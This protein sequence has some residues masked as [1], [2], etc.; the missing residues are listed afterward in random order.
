MRQIVFG[1]QLESIGIDFRNITDRGGMAA[2]YSPI[3]SGI[4]FPHDPDSRKFLLEL[5]RAKHMGLRR[6]TNRLTWEPKAFD[7]WRKQLRK[8]WLD[9]YVI[10]HRIGGPEPLPVVQE[11]S[12]KLI[13]TVQ[14]V[15]LPLPRS[16]WQDELYNIVQEGQSAS[17][18]S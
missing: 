6:E 5:L 9:L 2:G 13:T 11:E 14:T 7:S 17:A 16:Q 3:S 4:N 12:L 1:I 8:A 10:T 18:A 15:S